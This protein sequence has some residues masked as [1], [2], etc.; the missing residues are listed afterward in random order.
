MHSNDEMAEIVNK[1][2]TCMQEIKLRTNAVDSII[3]N[4]LQHYIHIQI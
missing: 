2:A 3:K 4:K 1:Y